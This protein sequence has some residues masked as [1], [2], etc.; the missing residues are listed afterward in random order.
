LITSSNF[1][2]PQVNMSGS[3][4]SFVRPAGTR[5]PGVIVGGGLG[6]IV[7]RR[8]GL[9]QDGSDGS[10]LD[11]P[12]FGGDGSTTTSVPPANI[13]MPVGGPTALD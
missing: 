10:I 11:I 5:V 8:R 3:M 7:R 6:R 13:S 1:Y 12:Y 9:G 4:A 2:V